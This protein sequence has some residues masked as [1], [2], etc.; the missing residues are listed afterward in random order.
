MPLHAAT[1]GEDALPTSKLDLYVKEFRMGELEAS[2]RTMKSG[3][4]HDYFEGVL[5]NRTGRVEE[6]IQLLNSALF[7]IR[8]SRKDRAAVALENLADD[9]NKT[10]R[11]ADAARVYDDLL[12]H[13]SDQLNG[14]QL[15]GTKED[16]GV[17]HLLGGAPAQTITW[18]GSTH[19]ETERNAIGSLVTELNTHGVREK[20]LLDTGANQSVVSRSFAKR[21]GLQPLPGFGQVMSGTTGME[22]PLQVALIPMLKVGGA[23]LRNVVVLI[24]DDGDLNIKLPDKTYQINGIIGYPVFQAMGAVTFSHDGSFKAGPTANTG[25]AGTQMYMKFLQPVIECKTQGVVLPFPLDTGANETVLSIR[26]YEQFKNDSKN[27]KSAENAT[28]GG[29]GTLR[30]KVFLVPQLD[31]Q[32]GTQMATL[33]NVPVFPIRIGSDRDEL[34]G[35]LGQDFVSGFESFTLDFTKMTFSLG[36]PL[37]ASSKQ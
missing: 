9:Y 26:Y 18:R 20:W 27:W 5:A 24:L 4:E 8:T 14:D 11:Y 6:S 13:F 37:S 25:M 35:N 30:R 29:G 3:P 31:L 36:K 17:A 34:Y 33:H 32:V 12:A 21:L 19:L 16:A 2:L 23:M 7:T 1:S 15:K 10:F 28:G 22:S